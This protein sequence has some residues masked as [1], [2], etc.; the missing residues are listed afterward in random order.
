MLSFFIKKA[1]DNTFFCDIIT[2]IT[3]TERVRIQPIAERADLWAASPLMRQ[4]T[5][6]HSRVAG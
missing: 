1:L 6:V 4:I 5:E 3:M 2:S